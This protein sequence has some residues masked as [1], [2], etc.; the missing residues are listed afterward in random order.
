[1][2]ITGKKI[3]IGCGVTVGIVFISIIV[4]LMVV[5]YAIESGRLPD[6]AAIPASKLH[7]RQIN[8]LEQLNIIKPNE[9]VHYFYSA[10]FFS[11]ENDGNLFTDE[12]VISYQEFDGKLDMYEAT[13]DEIASID[14]QPSGNWMEDSTITIT[15]KD[16]SWFMLYVSS[17]SKGDISFHKKLMDI[18]KSKTE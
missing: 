4:L 13:Y 3:A 11:I 1:M 9:K 16:D 17:E 14:F 18:W 10:A 6:T 12:R 8:Q 7:A 5:G 15:L 2:K